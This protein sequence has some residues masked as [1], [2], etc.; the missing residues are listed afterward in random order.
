M[1]AIVADDRWCAGRLR[2]GGRAVWATSVRGGG[3]GGEGAYAC[4]V[5]DG[6]VGGSGAQLVVCAVL[7]SGGGDGGV[8]SRWRGWGVA[9]CVR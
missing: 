1:L 5:G 3:L 2:V 8:G 9:G 6:E 7:G 4:V